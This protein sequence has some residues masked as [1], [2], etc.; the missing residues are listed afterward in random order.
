MSAYGRTESQQV[1]GRA[2][3]EIITAAHEPGIPHDFNDD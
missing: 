3:G 1:T 2:M